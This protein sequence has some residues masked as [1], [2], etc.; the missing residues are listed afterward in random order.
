VG[1]RRFKPIIKIYNKMRVYVKEFG[2]Y[3]D[4]SLQELRDVKSSTV[5]VHF[6]RNKSR[7]EETPV[8][9]LTVIREIK[10]VNLK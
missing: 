10:K 6:Y 7:K 1:R 9:E 2:S 4:V 3:G 5:N 8:Y